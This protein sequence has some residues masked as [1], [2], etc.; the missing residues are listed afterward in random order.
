M[1]EYNANPVVAIPK[2]A[3]KLINRA[4]DLL[5]AEFPGSVD[6]TP[7]KGVYPPQLGDPSH[8]PEGLCERIELAAKDLKE[9]LCHEDGLALRPDRIG[10]PEIYVPVK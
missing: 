7:E 9:A 5:G 4:A 2:N 1:A 3:L 10:C 8:L 6:L